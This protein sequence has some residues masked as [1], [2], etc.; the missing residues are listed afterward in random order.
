[1]KHI[2]ILF[3]ILF[4]YSCSNSQ[5]TDIEKTLIDSTDN[6][7]VVNENTILDSIIRQYPF[8]ENIHFAIFKY[9]HFGVSQV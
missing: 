7:H 3:F 9:S 8:K 2:C 6:Q 5:R 4:F 1:M